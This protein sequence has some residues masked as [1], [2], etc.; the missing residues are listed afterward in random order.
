[1]RQFIGSITSGADGSMGVADCVY[2]GTN[3][4]AI[5]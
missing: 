2:A 1:M 5:A 4:S 3:V